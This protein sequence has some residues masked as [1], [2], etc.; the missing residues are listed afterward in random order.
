MESLDALLDSGLV[1][2]RPAVQGDVRFETLQTIR[3]YGLERLDE[4]HEAPGVRRRHAQYFEELAEV[5][6]PELRGPQLERHLGVLVLEHDNLRAALGWA[7]AGDEG[8]VGLRLCRSLW[9]FWQLH[10]DLTTGRRWADQALAIPSAA[11]RTAVRAKALIAAGSLAYW[12]HDASAVRAMYGE[13]LAIFQELE[14]R[15][16]V[17]EGTYNVAFVAALEENHVEAVRLFRASRAMFE[18]LGDR[19]GVADSLFGLSNA[20]RFLGDLASAR[21]S[22]EEALRLHRE[23]GDFFGIHGDLYM[24]GRAAA[25]MGDLDTAR[26]QFLQTLALAEAIGYPTGIAL[27]FDQLADQAIKGGRAD[28]AM[29]LAG[30][31]DAIKEFVGG[32]APPELLGLPD[33]HERARQ[34]LT[35]DEIH[36]AVE[37]GRAMTREEAL[38]FARE[39]T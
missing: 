33:P 39:E 1:R 11:G 34:L 31:A 18:E 6:A 20:A 15:E 5:A 30:A 7:I 23:L 13:A 32:E 28:R 14:D 26:Q 22:S 38:A 3:E 10:G 2:R 27:S 25:E 9:R 17:A 12:Q 36:A 37:E 21:A 19:R 24:L 35:E 16:G 8:D 29:R 4:Q